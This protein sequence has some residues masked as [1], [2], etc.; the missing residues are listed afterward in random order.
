MKIE[1]IV[2]LVTIFMMANVY[3]DGYLITQLKSYQK[4][5]KMGMYAVGGLALYLLL[6]RNP[7]KSRELLNQASTV[8]KYMPIDRD[9]SRMMAPIFNFT[10]SSIPHHEQDNMNGH[11]NGQQ[12]NPYDRLNMYQENKMVQSGKKSTKRSVSETKKKWVA[13]NQNWTCGDCKS[14]LPAWFEV[15]HKV[16]LEYGGTNHV[17]NLVALCRDCH[18]RKTAS[19]NL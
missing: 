15:D 12:S 8:V 19:E 4:Y 3:Y 14:K 11:Y 13:S 6:K 1:F 16:R 10:Q 7:W 5:G 17:D 9:A 18:G 2:V